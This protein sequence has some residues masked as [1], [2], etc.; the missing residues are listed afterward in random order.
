VGNELAKPMRIFVIMVTL[1]SFSL[2]FPMLAKADNFG[3]LVQHVEIN[4]KV[5]KLG[6]TVSI[7]FD[8]KSNEKNITTCTVSAFCEDC[9]LG[10][11][12]ITV[13]AK[14]S[15]TLFFELDTSYMYTGVY[16]IEALIEISS[17]GQKTFNLG[18]IQI[19]AN[20]TIE[21]NIPTEETKEDN[22]IEE[23]TPVEEGNTTE[24]DMPV[25]EDSPT[26]ENIPVEEEHSTEEN[27]STEEN[28][29][30]E[31][32]IP[33]EEYSPTEENNTIKEDSPTEENIPVEEENNL[34]IDENKETE[35]TNSGFSNWQF[36]IPVVPIGAMAS[37]L[38][39]R[40]TRKES[41]DLVILGDQLSNSTNPVN[42][43]DKISHMFNEILTLEENEAEDEDSP[44]AKKKY[45]K[46]AR[47]RA[48]LD[49]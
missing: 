32:D 43:K 41:Q 47:A 24:E 8:I 19:E 18:N 13:G 38:V 5:A 16:S 48:L 44:E 39:L 2:F 40:R 29:P 11:Q 12:E 15:T 30:T 25:E 23:D 46:F 27:N 31:E 36:L 35:S 9:I 17:S 3:L 20:N 28:I 42:P 37:V 7:T 4:P 22:S 10:T 1:L 6:E 49:I 26:E 34:S 45:A 14:S 21:E 33:V